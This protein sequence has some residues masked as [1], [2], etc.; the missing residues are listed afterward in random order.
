MVQYDTILISMWRHIKGLH[1]KCLNPSKLSK[2]ADIVADMDQALRLPAAAVDISLT[3][4]LLQS[5]KPITNISHCIALDISQAPPWY[6]SETQR[7]GI[8]PCEA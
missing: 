7:R 4:A 3:A 6:A 8:C 5:V 1:L 2:W